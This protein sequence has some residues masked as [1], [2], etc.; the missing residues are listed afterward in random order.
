MNRINS[1]KIF[2]LPASFSISGCLNIINLQIIRN[3]KT[4]ENDPSFDH[5]WFVDL[6]DSCH[7]AR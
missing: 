5:G 7:R 3:E 2:S 6:I 4:Y 1:T